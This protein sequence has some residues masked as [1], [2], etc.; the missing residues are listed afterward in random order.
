ML[1]RAALAILLVAC[2]NDAD[3]GFEV[4]RVPAS[5]YTAPDA[6]ARD[7][8]TIFAAGD[9]GAEPLVLCIKPPKKDDDESD[10][11]AKRLEG[12][13]YDERATTRHRHKGEEDVCC[14]RRGRLPAGETE[15]DGD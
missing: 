4:V 1:S 11:C 9:G 12:R 6:G 14:Y 7:G 5:A 3:P 13:V 2:H 8:A 10:D 15:E